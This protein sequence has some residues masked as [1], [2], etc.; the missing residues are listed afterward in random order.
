MEAERDQVLDLV[1]QAFSTDG[2]DGSE[3]VGIVTRTWE[4]GASPPGLELVAVEGNRPVGHVLAA[5]GDLQ[6]EE[7][8]GIAPLSVSPDCQNRGVGTALMTELLQRA[9]AAGWPA[10]LVL[11]NPDYYGR[12]G[13]GPAWSLGIFYG[14][15]GPDDPHFQ[16]RRLGAAGPRN[17]GE[18]RYCW[19]RAVD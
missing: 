14:P 17:R 1:R 19:E 15:L 2:R 18:F 16:I 9:R 10:V 11:G 3:E 5:R 13:F 6:G 4:L 8:L 7:L 12:F